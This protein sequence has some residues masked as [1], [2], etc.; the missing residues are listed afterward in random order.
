MVGRQRA[1]ES[2]LYQR[3][4]GECGGV[5]NCHPD[6]NRDLM[7]FCLDPDFRRDDS[8]GYEGGGE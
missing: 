1:K 8:V 5:G 7:E 3:A 2:N 6:E 4:A